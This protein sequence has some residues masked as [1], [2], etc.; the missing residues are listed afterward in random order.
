MVVGG[1]WGLGVGI[2]EAAELGPIWGALGAIPES[3][4]AGATLGALG[5]SLSAAAG[6]AAGTLIYWGT[7]RGLTNLYGT[8]TSFGTWLYDIQPC[9]RGLNRRTMQRRPKYQI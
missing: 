9:K 1:Y 7:E 2:A 4:V 8:P 5:G 3:T 6:Y